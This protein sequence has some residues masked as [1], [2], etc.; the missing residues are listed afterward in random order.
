MTAPNA[1]TFRAL[2]IRRKIL[3][4]LADNYVMSASLISHT[5]L[6]S[7]ATVLRH[8]RVLQELDLVELQK[9]GRTLV[10]K[11]KENAREI[12]NL[13]SELELLKALD[14]KE[15]MNTNVRQTST[16]GKGRQSHSTSKEVKEG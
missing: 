7:Y 8:L 15:H 12:Q 1:H 3:K 14:A 5:L 10:A 11:I 16:L 9:E 6:L 4:L 13:N 2:A